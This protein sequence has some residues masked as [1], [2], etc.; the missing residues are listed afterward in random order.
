MKKLSFI[1]SII[2]FGFNSRADYFPLTLPEMIIQSDLIVYGEIVHVEDFTFIIQISGVVSGNYSD[3]TV[4]IRKFDDFS[5]AARWTKYVTGQHVFLFL[6]NN[7]DEHFWKILSDGGEGE[8]PLYDG[9]V[10]LSSWYAVDMPF[11]S[12]IRTHIN[13]YSETIYSNAFDLYG[14]R[15]YG[16]D[17]TLSEFIDAVKVFKIS[18][19]T[20]TPENEKS[21]R[22]NRQKLNT[23]NAISPLAN[24]LRVQAEMNCINY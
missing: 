23:L 14:G 10:Y 16:V 15:F 11:K 9:K 22:C 13:G 12:I 2:V 8:L 21:C 19:E 5:C 20:I 6:K 18:C 1:I 17:F 7:K 3:D 24:W 4:N